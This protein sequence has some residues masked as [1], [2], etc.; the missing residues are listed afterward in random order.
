M[1]YINGHEIIFGIVG[2]IET[3]LP[4]G[5]PLAIEEGYIGNCNTV[6]EVEDT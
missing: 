1:A 2:Q 3:P 4:A 5:D 6:T